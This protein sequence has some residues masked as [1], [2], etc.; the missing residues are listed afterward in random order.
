MGGNCAALTLHVAIV[1]I[2]GWF[3]AVGGD[4][5]AVHPSFAHLVGLQ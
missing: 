1:A 4:T 2:H 3:G 5:A